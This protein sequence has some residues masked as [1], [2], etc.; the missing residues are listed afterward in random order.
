[1]TSQMIWKYAIPEVSGNDTDMPYGKPLSVGVQNG[2]PYMWVQA[3]PEAERRTLRV[4]VFQAGEGSEHVMEDEGW[5]FLGTFQIETKDARTLLTGY[6]VGH[7]FYK[8][9]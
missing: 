1:M 6:Y 7:V 3:D 4:W 2:R 9:L 5:T 8:W